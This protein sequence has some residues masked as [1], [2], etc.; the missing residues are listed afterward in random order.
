MQRHNTG[1]A[2]PLGVFVAMQEGVE[3]RGSDK[4][5]AGKRNVADGN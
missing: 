3:R 4:D 1:Q 5:E 2:A